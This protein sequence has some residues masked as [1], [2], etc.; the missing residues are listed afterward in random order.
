M[1]K[2]QLSV[3]ENLNSKTKLQLRIAIMS[4]QKVLKHLPRSTKILVFF[5]KNF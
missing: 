1:Y 5:P 4:F 3:F 2:L